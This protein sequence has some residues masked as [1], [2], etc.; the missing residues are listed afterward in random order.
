MQG[1]FK[2]QTGAG[3]L[4]EASIVYGTYSFTG[5]AWTLAST[6][7]LLSAPRRLLEAYR[8]HFPIAILESPLP[9]PK[10][11][12]RMIWHALTHQDPVKAWL[13]GVVKEELAVAAGPRLR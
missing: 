11:Q 8:L 7:V 10:L 2:P 3:A 5:M 13:R 1:D 4:Q 6:D 12:I 9:R